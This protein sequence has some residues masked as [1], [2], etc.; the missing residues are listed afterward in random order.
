M[1][2]LRIGLLR[3]FIKGSDKMEAIKA[4]KLVR[5]L[6]NG[7]LS[8]L[9]INKKQRLEVGKVYHSELHDTKGFKVRQGWHCC[10][11]PKAPHLSD[12]DRVWVEIL[13]AGVTE[14]VRPKSQGGLWYTADEMKILRVLTPSSVFSINYIG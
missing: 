14:H 10:A 6:K 5:R 7:E 1:H 13:I 9:F 12:K 8:P 4:Y 3:I 2:Y 11:K